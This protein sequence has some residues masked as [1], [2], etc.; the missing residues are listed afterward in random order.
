MPLSQEV[1]AVYFTEKDVEVDWDK[2]ERASPLVESV[3]KHG[4]GD[5]SIISKAR[6]LEQFYGH[7]VRFFLVI[8]KNTFRI[9]TQKVVLASRTKNLM[10]IRNLL[11]HVCVSEAVR[12]MARKLHRFHIMDQIRYIR[13][14]NRRTVIVFF[15]SVQLGSFFM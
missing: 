14:N 9:S 1:D 15:L 6:R 4:R 12:R 5:P 11:V 10:C 13:Q 2:V 7:M 8:Q 3:F